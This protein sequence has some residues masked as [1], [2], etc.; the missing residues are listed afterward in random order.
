MLSR[1]KSRK[2]IR[3]FGILII[4]RVF[5]FFSPLYGNAHSST[6]KARSKKT[7]FIFRNKTCLRNRTTL[8]FDFLHSFMVRAQ[9]SAF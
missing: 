2:L 1:K 5:F 6:L 7:D 9:T 4:D 8:R 3:S